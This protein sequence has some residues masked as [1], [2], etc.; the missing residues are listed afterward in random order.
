MPKK[1]LIAGVTLNKNSVPFDKL[2]PMVTS[3]I[4]IGTPCV[5]TRGMGTAEMEEIADVISTVVKNINNPELLQEQSARVKMLCERS[6]YTDIMKC[7]FC[8]SIEDKVIDSRASKD[9]DVIRRRRECLKCEQ[10][11]TSTNGSKIHCRWLSRKTAVV[12]S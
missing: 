7:P 3:G 11:F 2:S 6:R 5:T 8:G 10:R 1:R 12:N 9:G 4:R